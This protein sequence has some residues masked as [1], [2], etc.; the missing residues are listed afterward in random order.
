MKK[1]AGDTPAAF[2]VGITGAYSAFS[3]SGN[4]S[5]RSATRP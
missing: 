3:S 4:T 2:F 1:A 5:N